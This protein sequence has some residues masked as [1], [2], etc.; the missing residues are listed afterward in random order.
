[1][2]SEF[3]GMVKW[4]KAGICVTPQDSSNLYISLRWASKI[5]GGCH[6][7]EPVC[8]VGCSTS[9]L[10]RCLRAEVM[11]WS[12][13]WFCVW[14]SG[15]DYVLRRFLPVFMSHVLFPVMFVTSVLSLLPM[16]FSSPLSQLHVLALSSFLVNLSWSQTPLSSPPPVFSSKLLAWEKEE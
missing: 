5:E 15:G 8:R 6:S 9:K 10:D 14:C 2:Q 7:L 11:V 16:V 3:S 12:D 13:L 4:N 1:M